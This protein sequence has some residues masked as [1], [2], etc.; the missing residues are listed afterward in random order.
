MK[1]TK[2]KIKNR[3]GLTLN[4]QLELPANQKPS[5]YAIFAH[6]FTCSSSLNAVRHVS[7]AL[8]QDGFGV[9][10]FDFTGLGSSE[11]EFADS[12]FS[13]NVE[14]LLDVH[15]YISQ[16]YQAPSLLVGH[17]LGG[18]AVLVA[19][20]KLDSVKAVATIGAPATV[21]HV[22][23]LFSH[24]IEN[25]E[26]KGKIKVDIGGRPFEIDEVFISEF[27]NTD[28]PAVVKDLRKPLLL[29]HAPFDTI[30][31]I[32]NAQ[33]L[34][35]MAHHP[36]SF[37][38]L[39]DADHLLSSEKD[40][41]YV[42]EVI[43][44]WAKRYFPVK[45]NQMLST[46]GEQLVGHLNVIE[47]NFT[48]T[49]QT[50]KHS[51]IADEPVEAGGNDFGPSP[52]E[53]LNAALAACTTMTLKLHAERKAWDLKEVY[54]YLSHAKTHTEDLKRNDGSPRY[55]DHITKRLKFVGNL[56]AN[57]I[58]KLTDIASRCPVHK[59]LASEVVF[60][61]EIIEP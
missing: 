26:E 18:A 47:D 56:E 31:G 37:I 3:K 45:E 57:Q 32:E 28:L 50:K 24:Q 42:G 43:G 12:H 10:R 9:I 21:D 20:S 39:D 36:K 52:Y 22:K 6:C 11:G 7:R 27:D 2:L 44:T 15:D 59:T 55:L 33:Q 54:V 8:A 49:I 48:T 29:M 61:T 17:S 16:H 30:V 51:L 41:S 25:I 13:A 23:R 46:Q 4:A 19:A 38:S 1:R 40:S 60:D 34:Y 5:H 14:D 53:Y 35:A 58:E